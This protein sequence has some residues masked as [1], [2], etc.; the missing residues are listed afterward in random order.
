WSKEKPLPVEFRQTLDAR[1]FTERVLSKARLGNLTVIEEPRLAEFPDLGS[2]P[3]SFV[4][5][6]SSS[7]KFIERRISELTVT[8]AIPAQKI[9]VTVSDPE[10]VAVYD[11]STAFEPLD[12]GRS[13]RFTSG[14]NPTVPYVIRFSSA[15][16]ASLTA[17]VRVWSRANPRGLT[18]LNPDI[19][20]SYLLEIDTDYAFPEG[21]GK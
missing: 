10:N 4:T 11:S 17:R 6:S 16:D 14:E 15:R 5:V 19:R 1:G 20:A 3:E 7:R 18:V 13:C 2:T 8:P 9:E 12:A 21:E